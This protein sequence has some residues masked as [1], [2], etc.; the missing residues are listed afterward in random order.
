MTNRVSAP[1]DEG[2]GLKIPARQTDATGDHPSWYPWVISLNACDGDQ[3]DP[4]P[5]TDR[6]RELPAPA[7]FPWALTE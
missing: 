5:L 6:E 4:E 2:I 7:A 1:A 3:A